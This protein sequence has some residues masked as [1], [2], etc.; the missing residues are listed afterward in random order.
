MMLDSHPACTVPGVLSAIASDICYLLKTSGFSICSWK[1]RKS[2]SPSQ[3]GV[4]GQRVQPGLPSRNT[5][6]AF[7]LLF[8]RADVMF[9]SSA[10]TPDSQKGFF[11]LFFSCSDRSLTTAY[12]WNQQGPMGKFSCPLQ[13]FSLISAP[14]TGVGELFFSTWCA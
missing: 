9:L 6:D 13:G 2:Q 7:C 3:R 5:H 8:E 10:E 1:N 4:R 11:L 14:V 12:F